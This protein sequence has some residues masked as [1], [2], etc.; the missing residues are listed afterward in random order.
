MKLGPLRVDLT[1]DGRAMPMQVIAGPGSE[2][3]LNYDLPP[4]FVGHP[5]IEVAFTV[6]RTI[7]PPGETRNLGLAFGQFT[8]K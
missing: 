4:D 2:F 3:R 5:K 8:I 7:K 6:D 1:I